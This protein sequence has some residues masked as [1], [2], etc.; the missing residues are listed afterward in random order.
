MLHSLR[1]A[2]R[3]DCLCSDAPGTV[4]QLAAGI[5]SVSRLT[6]FLAIA[7]TRRL[8]QSERVDSTSSGMRPAN[9]P[10]DCTHVN[11][12]VRGGMRSKGQRLRVKR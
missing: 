1:V 11:G 12:R 7:L 10:H 4:V 5:G 3:L 6:A 8:R 2:G 9:T